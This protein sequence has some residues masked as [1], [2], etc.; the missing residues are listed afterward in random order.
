MDDDTADALDE[1]AGLVLRHLAGRQ[2]LSMT[3]TACLARIRQDGPSRLTALAAAEGVSQPSMS[4]LVQR[5]ERQG[6]VARVGDP[7]DGRASLVALTESGRELLAD[8]R[9]ERHERFAELVATLPEEDAVALRLAMSVALPV[10]RRL[11]DTAREGKAEAA[12]A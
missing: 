9:R 7:E 10:V 8:R 11:V 1:V 4:Q 3:A 2:G 6:L 12:K 5:L